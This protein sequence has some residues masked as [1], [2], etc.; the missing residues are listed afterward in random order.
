[1]SFGFSSG[2]PAEPPGVSLARRRLL[3]VLGVAAAAMLGA[4]GKKPGQLRLPEPTSSGA[5]PS[6]EED[7]SGSQPSGEEAK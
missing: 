3:A 7:S 2:D 5:Q 1:V 6:D 4:C